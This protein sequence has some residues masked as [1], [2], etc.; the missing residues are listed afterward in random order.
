MTTLRRE[1]FRP[2]TYLLMAGLLL[3]TLILCLCVGSVMIPLSDTFEVLWSA[4][5]GQPSGTPAHQSILLHVR[6]PRVLCVGLSGAALS[7]GGAAMQGLLRN[8]LAEGSTLGVSSGASLGAVLAIA[9]GFTIPGIP[10]AGTAA[11]AVLFAFLSLMLILSLSLVMDRSLSTNTLILVGVVFSLF[12]S[13]LINVVIALYSDKIR[14][15]AF[16]TMGSLAG[17]TYQDAAML[18][19]ALFLSSLVLFPLASE[20]NAFA[21]G[22]ENARHVGVSVKRVKLA[23]MISVCVLIGVCV[24]VGGTIGFVGLVVPHIVRLMTGPNHKR[25]LP[26]SA[27]IGAVFL[28]LSD[29]V[30][31]TVFRPAELP[32]GVITSLVG[33]VVFVSIMFRSRKAVR[34]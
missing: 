19:I 1:G 29:L 7:L 8:P 13:S 20:L 24:A 23:I 30:A 5:K 4:I 26:G 10:L 21:V 2:A 27:F 3:L 16:W 6:L 28:L 9:M 15:I 11:M 34:T 14:S 31:R 22:E 12:V 32:I 33:A 18:A 25:L 17:S